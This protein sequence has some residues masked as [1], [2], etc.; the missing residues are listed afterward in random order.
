VNILKDKNMLKFA[1]ILALTSTA[2]IV[3]AATNGASVN[4]V[5]Q[6]TTVNCEG[7]PAT[8]GGVDNKVTFIGN[9]TSLFVDGTDNEIRINLSTSAN[10]TVKGVDNRIYWTAPKGKKPRVNISGVDNVVLRAK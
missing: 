6:E 3:M 1:A 2:G 8:V 4:G 10:V 5:E 9:C 7:G